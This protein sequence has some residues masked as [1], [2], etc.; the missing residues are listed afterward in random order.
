MYDI[1]AFIAIAAKEQEEQRQS[2]LRQPCRFPCCR[3]SDYD[4]RKTTDQTK[5]RPVRNA[6]RPLR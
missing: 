6:K 2:R 4:G 5:R 1:D 3:C